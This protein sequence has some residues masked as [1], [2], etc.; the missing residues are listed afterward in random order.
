MS[1]HTSVTNINLLQTIILYLMHNRFTDCSLR[2][3]YSL[4]GHVQIVSSSFIVTVIDNLLF[5]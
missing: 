1:S 4:M 2:I 3:V 5:N